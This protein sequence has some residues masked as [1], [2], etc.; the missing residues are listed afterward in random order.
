MKKSTP[1]I[2]VFYL[3]TELLIMSGVCGQRGEKDYNSGVAKYDNQ[4]YT[5]A[6]SY[7]TKAIEVYPDDPDAYLVRGSCKIYLGQ[8]ESGCK[9]LQKALELGS[10][11]AAAAI[12]KF[13]Q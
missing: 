4:D 12:M 5:G 13:C 2:I 1:T 10:T 7:Y 6:I 9:D 3:L 8:K 11:M